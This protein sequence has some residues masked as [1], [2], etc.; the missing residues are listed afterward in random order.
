MVHVEVFVLLK[1]TQGCSLMHYEVSTNH[2]THCMSNLLLLMQYL[3]N[4]C[5]IEWTQLRLEQHFLNFA[6]VYPQVLYLEQSGCV[7]WVLVC[8]SA[9]LCV[10]KNVLNR[11]MSAGELTFMCDHCCSLAYSTYKDASV[12]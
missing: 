2:I 10:F 5:Y 4:Y 1:D 3:G 7:L 11:S 12:S 8:V 6:Y 9:Y